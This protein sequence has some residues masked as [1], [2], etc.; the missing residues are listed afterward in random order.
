MAIR[1]GVQLPSPPP[2]LNRKKLIIHGFADD[3]SVGFQ[4]LMGERG[5][6]T[7]VD[8]VQALTVQS[9]LAMANVCFFQPKP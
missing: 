1:T 6:Q 9:A 7:Q 5:E 8:P 4:L 2:G 3:G